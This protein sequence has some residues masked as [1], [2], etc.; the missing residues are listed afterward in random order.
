MASAVIV[1]DV[2][3]DIVE[4][5]ASTVYFMHGHPV[6]VVN[7]LSVK[8]QD[9]SLKFQRFP[10]IAL[11]HDF[12]EAKGNDM[13]VNSEVNLNLIIATTTNPSYTPDQRYENS[14]STVL[15]PLYNELLSL[16]AQSCMFLNTAP[17]MIPHDK[18]DRLFW[19]KTG[20]YGNVGNMFNDYIDAIEISNLNLQIKNF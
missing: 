9:K 14:F 7:Q 15:Y 10:L 13:R 4:S 1:V 8:N 3:K 6:D 16:I 20:L 18:T 2:I 12:T 11:F 19:G 5:M 17:D